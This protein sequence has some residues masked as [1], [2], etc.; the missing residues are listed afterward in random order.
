MS[1]T[2][3]VDSDEVRIKALEAG[4]ILLRR[5]L[6][7]LVAEDRKITERLDTL[8]EG[9]R[10]VRKDDAL[11]TE[12]IITALQKVML[13]MHRVEE[14]LAEIAAGVETVLGRMPEKRTRRAK[15]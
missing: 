2:N 10:Q 4:Q 6:T 3:G 9:Q 5:D 14:S 11:T 8:L 7:A 1:G 15:R 13:R 12:R